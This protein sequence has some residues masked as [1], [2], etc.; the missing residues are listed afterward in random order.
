MDAYDAFMSLAHDFADAE[1]VP[2]LPQES[3][4]SAA[5][6][7]TTNVKEEKEDDLQWEG[8]L[9]WEMQEEA[10][11]QEEVAKP[12]Q[13][14]WKTPGPMA[15]GPASSSAAAASALPSSAAAASALPSSGRE[16][17]AYLTGEE[18][19]LFAKSGRRLVHP[20]PPGP[21]PDG[22]GPS[23]LYKS[24]RWRKGSQRW[25]NRGGKWADILGVV[26]R[27]PSWSCS[28]PSQTSRSP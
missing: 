11:Q 8:G 3:A 4:S 14:P 2:P 12:R 16:A 17:S 5:A 22:G 26:L 27:R 18:P 19:R 9:D 23:Q 25:A 13:P 28:R 24:Q 20:P 10:V 1:G 7:P 15:P 6:A 21:D